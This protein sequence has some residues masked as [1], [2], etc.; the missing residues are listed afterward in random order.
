MLA[1]FQHY[2]PRFLFGLWFAFSMTLI[3]HKRYSKPSLFARFVML[4]LISAPLVSI[5]AEFFTAYTG[6]LFL[7]PLFQDASSDVAVV[8]KL[9]Y[10]IAIDGL[11]LLIPMRLLARHLQ[12]P[13]LIGAGAYMLYVI[14]DRLGMVVAISPVTY[15]IIII[16][17]QIAAMSIGKDMMEYVVGKAKIEEWKPVL[18]YL[19]GL[20]FLLVFLYNA[21]LVFPELKSGVFDAQNLWLDTIA[22]VAVLFYGLFST[23]NIKVAKEQRD[24]LK[25]LEDL[26]ENQNN[27]IQT[28]SE[29]S[30]A[31]SGETGQHIKRVSE[32]SRLLAENYGLSEH[33]TEL[34]RTA[35]MMHDVGKLLIPREIIE[36]PG[37]LT[38]E[39][40]A[41]MSEHTTYGQQLLSNSKGEIIE[42]ARTIAYEHHERW[43]GTGYP[44]K[45][46]G[47]KISIYAQIVAVAD[48]F[49]ALTSVRSYKAAWTC[50]DARDEIIRQRGK[51]FS[52]AVVDVFENCYD[53]ILEIHE[54][55]AD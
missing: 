10:T 17:V 49:D 20:F 16:L 42:M 14:I 26:K 8:S 6:E 7:L 50:E 33:E 40:R 54:A 41:I 32:Y 18:L 23:V 12:E 53:Q 30:E 19:M 46:S 1:I 51:Q 21:D 44:C 25:Y 47:D 11:S 36:K 31:K 34:I 43:D 2:W 3:A 22:I 27:I 55:N 38:D 52:P 9:V 28:L 35:S 37:K 5:Y 48:V 4:F 24:K 15:L 39:E 29:F 13:S 45:I